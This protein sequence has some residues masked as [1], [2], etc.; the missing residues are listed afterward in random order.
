MT[1]KEFTLAENY[2]LY[3]CSNLV[4]ISRSAYD[5]DFSSLKV[6]SFYPVEGKICK[7]TDVKEFENY[8]QYSFSDWRLGGGRVYTVYHNADAEV[9]RFEK[10]VD[11]AKERV[12]RDNK[13]LCDGQTVEA[14]SKFEIT[15][16]TAILDWETHKSDQDKDIAQFYEDRPHLNHD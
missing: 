4:S 14:L 5:Y 13:R 2:R 6:G 10:L 7:L 3:A 11:W 9:E 8:T 12:C 15:D 1:T 16:A